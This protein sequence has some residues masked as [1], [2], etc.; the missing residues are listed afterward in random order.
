MLLVSGR[1]EGVI[2]LY[3]FRANA[4]LVDGFMLWC[5]N[6]AYN[7]VIVCSMFSG[8]FLLRRVNAKNFLG[9]KE[10]FNSLFSCM[11]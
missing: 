2:V 5:D 1:H 10:Y 4:A 7:L 8:L 9:L 3:R 6:Q 11:I